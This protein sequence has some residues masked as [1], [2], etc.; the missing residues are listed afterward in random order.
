MNEENLVNVHWMTLI[1]LKQLLK[2]NKLYAKKYQCSF[3]ILNFD[4]LIKCIKSE[5]VWVDSKEVIFN[6]NE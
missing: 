4:C 3:K 1:S 6:K 2:E 5:N